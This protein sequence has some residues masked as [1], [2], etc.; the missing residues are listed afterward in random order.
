[1]PRCAFLRPFTHEQFSTD[2]AAGAQQQSRWPPLKVLE[3]RAGK[4]DMHRRDG[5]SRRASALSPDLIARG[6]AARQVLAVTA[7]RT[8]S[9]RYAVVAPTLPCVGR[10]ADVYNTSDGIASL[11]RALVI[12]KAHDCGAH[13]IASYPSV[14][15]P[16]RP[17]P[18]GINASCPCQPNACSELIRP[19]PGSFVGARI[20]LLD[21][22]VAR[23][24]AAGGLR[25]LLRLWSS[26][27]VAV[28]PNQHGRATTCRLSATFL[29]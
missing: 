26:S 22:P 13:G 25:R 9:G 21:P 18:S 11:E 28:R 8:G 20:R 1:M 23:V 16:K 19:S 24:T 29:P 27:R 7:P 3:S 15:S 6:Y 4:A 17:E 12:K 2:T 5:M 10:L 14:T